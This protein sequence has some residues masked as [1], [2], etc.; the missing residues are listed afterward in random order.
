MLLTIVA[1]VPP[2]VT[3]VA[4]VKFVPLI[5]S[6]DPGQPLVVA[7]LVIVGGMLGLRATRIAP[8]LDEVSVAVPF[9]VAPAVAL[10]AQAPP[11]ETLVACAASNNSVKAVTG[12]AVDHPVQVVPLLPETANI[13]I[14]ALLVTDVSPVAVTVVRLFPEPK[15]GEATSRGVELSTPEKATIA[16]TVLVTSVFKVNV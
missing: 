14:A 1:E 3:E 8:A 6:V 2:I 9:P 5:V 7:K 12:V 4:P 16:P 15:A 10:I 13:K 11:T